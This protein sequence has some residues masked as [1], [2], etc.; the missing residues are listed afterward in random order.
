MSHPNVRQSGGDGSSLTPRKAPGWSENH[1]G[2]LLK[3]Y[4]AVSLFGVLF[5]FIVSVLN[6][7]GDSPYNY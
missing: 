6:W 2:H 4:R 3:P 7:E 5:L 1:G